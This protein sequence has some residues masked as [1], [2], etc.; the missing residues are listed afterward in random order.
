ML[1]A[2]LSALAF[3]IACTSTQGRQTSQQASSSPAADGVAAEP[4]RARW[5]PPW[6]KPK[7]IDLV[8][9]AGAPLRV[10]IDHALATNTNNPGDRFT[11]SLVE[12]VIVDGKAVIPRGARV[13]GIVR[14][15]SPSGRL[16]GRAILSLTVN[17]I[18]WNGQ[19][20]QVETTAFTRTSSGHKKRNWTLIGG[21]S[22]LGA[23]IG[24]L[25]SGGSGAAIGAGAGA[26]AGTA[27]AAI[28]GKRQVRLPAEAL[29]SFKTSQPITV[30]FTPSTSEQEPS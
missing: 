11:G 23:L 19:S 8:V 28:T 1:A 5:T 16:K 15:S 25:A 3:Q 9:P 22:G 6:S 21:G 18:D 7:P 30:K 27:G 4:D 20:R 13:E 24:G 17:R 2:N 26:A 14:N 10:R 29:L 12:P